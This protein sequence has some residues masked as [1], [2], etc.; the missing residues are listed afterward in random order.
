MA[1]LTIILPALGTATQL[2]E[3]LVSVLQNRP[4]DSD[5]LV[6]HPGNY[7]DP[8]D[9]AGEVNFL[10]LP[11]GT[12]LLA[13]LDAAIEAADSDLLHILAPGTEVEEG[14]TD[15]ALTHFHNGLVAAV[16]PTTTIR[17]AN[18]SATYQGITSA[19]AGTSRLCAPEE[20]A[21]GPAWWSAFYRRQAV[22]D[23][24]GFD[25]E[26]GVSHADLDLA[27]TLRRL[28]YRTE[29]EPASRISLKAIPSIEPPT[30][31]EAARAAERFHRRHGGEQGFWGTWCAYPLAI[32][33]E[34][35]GGISSGRGFL[36]IAGRIAGWM[37]GDLV[38]PYEAKVATLPKA[39]VPEF[40][41][42]RA[43]SA[44]AHVRESARGRRTYQAGTP[45]QRKAA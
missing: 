30:T 18:G 9:L 43:V 42:L 22:I 28:G 7:A 24:G 1:R 32:A 2:E 21:T 31:W 36:A 40:P 34:M 20:S 41:R 6:V 23:A 14:W 8:Y 12:G 16:A 37:E 38:A 27:L 17:T 3:T 5:L 13:A 35:F 33:G 10:S 39:I 26:I 11:S 15:V 44:P 4:D 25:A 45:G 19:W 29:A